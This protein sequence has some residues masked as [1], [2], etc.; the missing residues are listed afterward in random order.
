MG[1]MYANAHD[2]SAVLAKP[3]SA[4]PD[5]GIRPGP[6]ATNPTDEPTRGSPADPS[7]DTRSRMRPSGRQDALQGNAPLRPG[8]VATSRKDRPSLDCAVTVAGGSSDTHMSH[9]PPQWA[10]VGS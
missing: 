10:T 2:P 9:S 1:V 7:R 3:A 4:R 8:G 5:A 6:S